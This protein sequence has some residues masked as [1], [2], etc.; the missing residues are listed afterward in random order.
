LDDEISIYTCRTASSVTRRDSD[1]LS[2]LLL[3]GDD[4]VSHWLFWDGDIKFSFWQCLEH[5]YSHS[6]F[7]SK[8]SKSVDQGCSIYPAYVKIDANKL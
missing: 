7:M 3:G 1:P 4:Q 6:F 2:R 8:Y 5:E